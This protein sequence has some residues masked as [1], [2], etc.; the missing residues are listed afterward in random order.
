[1]G[2]MVFAARIGLFCDIKVFGESSRVY[3]ILVVP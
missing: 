1:M 2:D 3:P